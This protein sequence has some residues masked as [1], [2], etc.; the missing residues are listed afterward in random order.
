[1]VKLAVLSLLLAAPAVLGAERFQTVGEAAASIK[2]VLFST[3]NSAA[4]NRYACALAP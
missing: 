1:M 4:T 2:V 3:G